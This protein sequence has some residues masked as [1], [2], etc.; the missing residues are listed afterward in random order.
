MRVPTI[1][2]DALDAR[3]K[4]A[5]ANNGVRVRRIAW[6]M[7]VRRYTCCFKPQTSGELL[8]SVS[9]YGEQLPGSPFRCAVSTPTPAASNCIVRG[10]GLALAVSRKEQIFEILF[11]DATGA[12]RRI[13]T[14]RTHHAV[15]LACVTVSPLC[16]SSPR[17]EATCPGTL[18]RPSVHA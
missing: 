6:P 1:T 3:A 15:S 9:L 2:S 18:P 4:H 7:R 5:R 14:P 13:A 17:E 8:I 16:F 10:E 11:R 12:V